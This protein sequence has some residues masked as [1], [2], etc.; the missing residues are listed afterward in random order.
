MLS[1]D[2]HAICVVADPAAVEAPCEPRVAAGT[3]LTS[4]T[5]S[6]DGKLIAAAL[7]APEPSDATSVTL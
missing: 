5:E 3:T 1:S 6:P 4:P 2:M 7:N